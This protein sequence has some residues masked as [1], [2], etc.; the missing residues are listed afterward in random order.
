MCLDLFDRE[1]MIAVRLVSAHLVYDTDPGSVTSSGRQKNTSG[2][3]RVAKP[4][5]ISAK[6]EGEQRRTLCAFPGTGLEQ[7]LCILML[8]NQEHLR[9]Q[10]KHRNSLNLYDC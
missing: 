2:I 4:L 9:G 3:I 10:N 6:H 7:I 1:S 8:D 5:A